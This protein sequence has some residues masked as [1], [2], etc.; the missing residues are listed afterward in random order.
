L[1]A[2][3]STSRFNGESVDVVPISFSYTT[4]ATGRQFD[5][6][7]LIEQWDDAD[8]HTDELIALTGLPELHLMR[9]FG[10]GIDA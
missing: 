9:R 10:S 4:M 2:R 1:M 3:E 5:L 8:R 7:F 6:P